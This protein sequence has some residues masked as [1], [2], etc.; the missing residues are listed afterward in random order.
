MTEDTQPALPL[1][2]A[3]REPLDEG[4]QPQAETGTAVSE[5]VH[6]TN[7]QDNHVADVNGGVDADGGDLNEGVQ[8]IVVTDPADL[9]EEKKKKKKKKKNKKKPASKRGLGKPTGMEPFFADP[10]L[11]PAEHAEEQKLYDSEISFLDRLLTAIQRFE[12]TRRLVSE[13]RDVF[14]KWLHYGGIKVGPNIGV[15][16]QDQA[17]MDKDQVATALSRVQIPDELREALESTDTDKPKYAVDFLGCTQSFMA[18]SAPVLFAFDTRDDVQF[19]TRTVERFLDYLLQHDVCPE[20]SEKILEARKFCR[21]ATDQMWACAEAQ[22]WMP[23]QFNMACSTKYGS[24][25]DNFDGT[26]VWGGDT[27]DG[28]AVFVG[29][30]FEEADAIMRYAVAGA[31]DQD[32]YDKF[33]QLNLADEDEEGIKVVKVIEGQGF[34]IDRLEYPTADCIGFYTDSGVDY[35]P[36]GKVFAKAWQDPNAPPEDLTEEERKAARSEQPSSEV[37]VFFVEEIVLQHLAKGQKILATVRQLNCGI[38]FFDDFTKIYPEF[39]LFLLNELVEDYKEPRY[40]PDAYVPGAPGWTEIKNDDEEVIG[41][42]DNG[43]SKHSDGGDMVGEVVG[44][45]KVGGEDD[46]EAY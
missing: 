27:Y 40:L 35:R 20:F 44:E 31:A 7:G 25:G 36:Q 12:R 43:E 39:D 16:G 24:L 17:E 18:R 13:Q 21:E 34:E 5:S 42:R 3:Q 33:T 10:P 29:L 38:W 30:T 2:A 22:R 28:T 37:Y 46:E 8:G 15:G 41:Y 23:G 26:S 11:T 9:P 32:V 6:S 4:Q 14:Y 45:E 1:V 19:V